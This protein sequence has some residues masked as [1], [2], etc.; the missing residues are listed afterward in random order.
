MATNDMRRPPEALQLALALTRAR[1]F[2]EEDA[3][4]AILAAIKDH[5]DPDMMGHVL[6]ELAGCVVAAA[7]DGPGLAL[8]D[9]FE[10]E[11]ARAVRL[12]VEMDVT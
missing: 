10:H 6:I 12:E 11:Q 4:L 8:C 3:K 2:Q 9:W 1:C 7:M 5:S